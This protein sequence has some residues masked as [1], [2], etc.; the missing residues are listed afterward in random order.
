[1][2]WEL[3]HRPRDAAQATPA[4]IEAPDSRSAIDQLRTQIPIGDVVLY[5]RAAR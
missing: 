1:M 2:Q 4:T 5:V 3:A